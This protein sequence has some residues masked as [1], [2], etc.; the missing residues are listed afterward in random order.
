VTEKDETRKAKNEIQDT[1][2]TV[3]RNPTSPKSIPPAI[4]RPYRPEDFPALHALD[5]ACFPAGIAYSKTTLRYFLQSPS[6]NCI[7]ATIS[8]EIAGFILTET[9]FP[10]AHIVTLDIAEPHRKQGLGSA[11]LQQAE[12]N[13]QGCGVQ[14]IILE[15]AID[16]HAAIAF[17]QHHGYR[18]EAIL[19]RYYQ[20]RLDA[21]EMIK[22][23]ALPTKIRAAH[24][25]KNAQKEN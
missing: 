24:A 12:E 7:V 25:V 18:I 14:Q 4:L 6:A 3:P 2:H 17:W 13:L 1:I 11:L 21:Y 8:N 5:R 23:P 19:K 20:G 9:E 16:N 10:L 15:T 22:H